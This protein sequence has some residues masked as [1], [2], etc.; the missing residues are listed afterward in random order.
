LAVHPVSSRL[1]GVLFQVGLA[2][3]TIV[4]LFVLGFPLLEFR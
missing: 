2:A 1:L 4:A 3:I